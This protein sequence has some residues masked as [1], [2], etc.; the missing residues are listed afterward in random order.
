MPKQA[1]GAIAG[2]AGTAVIAVTPRGSDTWRVTQ[3][4]VSML[5]GS[6]TAVAD[7]ATCAIYLEGNFVTPVVA[8]G[9]AAEGTPV[10]VQPN[11][12]LTVEW[13]GCTPGNVCKALVFYGLVA[14]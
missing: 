10:D 8:Q 5:A 13:S 12:V 3:V 6:A 1:Y 4:S 2:A 9:D 11:E 7:A 14:G